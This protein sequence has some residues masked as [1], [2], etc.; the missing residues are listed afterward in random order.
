MTINN[1]LFDFDG[2]ILDSNFLKENAYRHILRNYPQEKIEQFIS[3]HTD[4]GAIS[5]FE[6]IKY[7]FDTI[8]CKPYEQQEYSI[9]LEEFSEY[10]LRELNNKQLLIKDTMLFI[11]NTCCNLHIV[12][13]TEEN[14]LRHICKSLGIDDYFISIHGS[15]IQKH[16]LI[17]NLLKKYE[18]LPHETALV[19]DSI[20]DY[21]AAKANGIVFFGFNNK[22]LS[23]MGLYIDNYSILEKA[24]AGC[25]EP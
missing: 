18:Y 19:G 6:K 21:D 24:T 2:V 8:I 13:G 14:D 12:S 7:F 9:M 16:I 22:K 5:R 17:K 15:P 3:Y 1:I 4:N 25:N 10:T 23:K 11:K 20:N